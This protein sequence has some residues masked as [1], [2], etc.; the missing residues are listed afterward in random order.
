MR[1]R[2]FMGHLQQF[3]AVSIGVLCL[4]AF[5]FL[6]SYSALHAAAPE[7]IIQYTENYVN[8]ISEQLSWNNV[9]MEQSTVLSSDYRT[10]FLQND[11]TLIDRTA[12]LRVTYRLLKEI[13]MN[14]YNFFVFD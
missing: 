13:S 9:Y 8:K 14:E 3:L 6:Y 7:N 10:M 4:S 5:V 11:M 1:E 12:E 2:F